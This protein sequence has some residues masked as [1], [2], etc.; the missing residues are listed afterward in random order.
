MTGF[1]YQH[2]G[3]EMAQRDFP[4]TIGSPKDGLVNFSAKTVCKLD[5]IK[6]ENRIIFENAVRNGELNDFQFWGLPRGAESMVAKM[7]FDS[8]LMLMSSQFFEVIGT[9][10]TRLPRFDDN[11]SELLW[12]ESNFPIILVL[13]NVEFI[14][15]SFDDFKDRLGFH[16]R[17]H[18]RGNTMRVGDSRIK[19]AGFSNFRDLSRWCRSRQANEVFR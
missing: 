9:V 1:Y 8:E 15:L 7:G 2:V 3:E 5:A 4:K 13:K 10:V 11:L 6:P 16:D 17:Y 14:D 12:G 18:M 19:D